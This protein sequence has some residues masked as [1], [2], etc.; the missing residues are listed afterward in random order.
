MHLRYT[1]KSIRLDEPP[2]TAEDPVRFFRETWGTYQK[3]ISGNHM[4]HREI[5]TAVRKVTGSLP[6]PLQVLDLGCG[7]AAGIP[8]ILEP[9][10]VAGYRGCDL[11]P[12]ALDIARNNLAPLGNRAELLCRDMI[13]VLKEAPG[14]H[15]DVVYSSYALHHL[16]IREKQVFYNECRRVLRDNGCMILVDVMRDEGESREDYFDSYT[17]AV[18]ND[19]TALADIEKTRLEEHIRSCDYPEPSSLLVTLAEN[20]GLET[21]RRLEKHS[22]HQAWCYLV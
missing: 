5:A 2:E 3:V 16:Y 11:S 22:W 4:F 14:N 12:H 7:D 1:G 15:F 17:E 18:Q 13:A 6:G 9:E 19:W 10:E 21:C 20:A 8:A